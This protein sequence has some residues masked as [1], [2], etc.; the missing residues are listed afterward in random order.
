MAR[1]KIEDM[2]A[3]EMTEDDIQRVTGG[4]SGVP[5]KTFAIVQDGRGTYLKETIEIQSFSW[6]ANNTG[7]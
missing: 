4:A 1:I 7:G 6:G 5:G 2:K 3:I